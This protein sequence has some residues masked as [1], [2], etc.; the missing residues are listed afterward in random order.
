MAVYKLLR[1][2]PG[3]HCRGAVEEEEEQ[4]PKKESGRIEPKMTALQLVK[5]CS[6]HVHF[7]HW[8]LQMRQERFEGEAVGSLLTP[9]CLDN[10]FGHIQPA[11]SGPFPLLHVL[12]SRRNCYMR[13]R[14]AKKITMSLVPEEKLTSTKFAGTRPFLDARCPQYQ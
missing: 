1:L 8:E 13:A 6:L 2:L 7:E 10:T 14:Q 3:Q 4:G 12:L 5:S 11:S 9:A